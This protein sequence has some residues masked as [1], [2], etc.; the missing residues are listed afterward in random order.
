LTFAVNS[1][2]FEVLQLLLF[3]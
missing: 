3:V 2:V 1:L